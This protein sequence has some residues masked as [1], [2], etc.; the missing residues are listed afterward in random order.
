MPGTTLGQA[1]S[2][3]CEGAAGNPAESQG[4]LMP[5][6]LPEA[7]LEALRRLPSVSSVYLRPQLSLACIYPYN[8][9]E[10]LRSRNRTREQ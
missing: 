3:R 5:L 10:G 2:R 1:G 9:V 6:S 4:R 8:A 7:G